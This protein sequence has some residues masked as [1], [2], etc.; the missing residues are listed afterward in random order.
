LSLSLLLIASMAAVHGQVVGPMIGQVGSTEARFLYRPD[1]VVQSLRAS[2]L[3]ASGTVVG[4]DTQTSAAA[5]DYAVHFHVTGLAPYTTYGYRIDQ[6]AGDGSATLLAGND[7]QHRFRTFPGPGER[8]LFTAAFASCANATSEPVWARID[9][10]NVDAMFFMG[11][12]PYIDTS[13]A[14]TVLQKQRDFLRTPNISA[15]IAHVP[16]AATWDDHDFGLNNGNGLTVPNKAV[17]RAGFVNY[18]AH[19][20]YG[21]GTEGIYNKV[22]CGPIEVFMIDDRWFT[23]TA[24]SSVAPG[25][26]TF[27]GN[28][29]WAWLLDSL[30][31]SRAPFKV[32]SFGAIWQDKK[33][34]ENDDMQTYYYERDAMLDYIR[35]QRIPGVVLLGGD[36]HVS[37]HLIHP[38]RLGYDLHDFVS[39]PAHTSTIPSLNVYNP[40]LEWTSE[41]PQQFLTLTSDTRV[42]PAALTARYYLANGT[43]Q[44]TVT[45]PYDKL[46]PQEGTGLAKDLRAY[47]SFDQNG[48]N[49][50]VLGSRI[51]TTP[52]NGATTGAPGGVRSG[53]ASFTASG[54]QYLQVTRSI[55][56]EN[57]AKYTAAAWFKPAT[58]PADGSAE[59]QYLMESTPAGATNTGTTGY[60]I[61]VGLQAGTSA[62]KVGVVLYTCTLKPA[63][64][65]SG[66]TNSP[67]E[68][69]QGPFLTQVD[70]SL[71]LNHWSHLAVTF[72]SNQLRLFLNGQAVSTFA[73]PT[74]GALAENGGLIL[75]GHRGGTGRSYNGLLD[76]A[77]IWSRV[78]DDTEISS[79]WN[80]GNPQAIPT[81]VSMIDSDGDSL[82]DWWENTNGLDANNATDAIGDTDGDGIPAFIEY[83]M[84]TSPLHDDTPF[85]TYLRQI[86]APGQSA[87]STT[88]KNPADNSLRVRLTLETSTDLHSW[89]TVPLGSPEAG[90][91]SIDNLLKLKL[92]PASGQQR[93]YRFQAKAP[94]Q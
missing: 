65:S 11:D 78:L 69:A 14:A 32:V 74:P 49:Q 47:W 55:L 94:Q 61:S 36:I 37:R 21:T 25:Q 12:T 19:A 20:Q 89:Q 64:A 45:I 10:L 54:S 59:K 86:A 5:S 6:I 90:I 39:S 44:R 15:L 7:E 31:Q 30:K 16:S 79:L 77:A 85:Y 2:V 8:G 35:A 75:G 22:P 88:F 57:S 33:G 68:L 62:D 41:Q 23:Q 73:L 71:L 43:L 82:P 91:S 81:T 56:P 84:G 63:V 46:V 27:F 58:L 17:N 13:T 4:S 34:S 29:Q 66:G 18:R 83:A 24:T 9:S 60:C 51:N 38:Q 1:G 53:A 48:T 3:D 40:D 28:A 80:Q 72:D 26:P 67:T 76:E 42:Q 93:F 87:D 70:R 52:V 92:P 50:S